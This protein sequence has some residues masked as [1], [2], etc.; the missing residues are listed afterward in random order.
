[1]KK[2]EIIKLLDKEV[3]L[4]IIET[5]EDSK[6][7]EFITGAK[8][9][10]SEQILKELKE[11]RKET[12]ERRK[13]YIKRLK[14]IGTET[15]ILFERADKKIIQNSTIYVNKKIYLIGNHVVITNNIFTL[16]SELKR[17]DGVIVCE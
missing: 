17:E 8:L 15:Q 4:A 6:G 1:M 3:G 11:L 12:D 9:K 16:A 5:D 14:E 2:E 13:Y 10:D 7:R